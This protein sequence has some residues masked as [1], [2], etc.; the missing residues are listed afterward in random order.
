MIYPWIHRHSIPPQFFLFH[1]EDSFL[2]LQLSHALVIF[3]TP[4][5]TLSVSVSTNYA[6]A[7]EL[8]AQAAT[9]CHVVMLLYFFIFFGI[10]ST[11]LP[12]STTEH[13]AGAQRP[14]QHQTFFF[15]A[16]AH[17]E[18]VIMSLRFRDAS[19]IFSL[20]LSQGLSKTPHYHLL[21]FHIV[22]I[23]ESPLLQ[24]LSLSSQTLSY[25]LITY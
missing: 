18:V 3:A 20:A 10:S 11:P 17:P 6:C 13:W 9:H 7:E 15:R 4:Y 23:G 14:Q 1:T 16:V 21:L 24:K 22:Y 25:L 12:S 2:L 8:R 19:A 5:L